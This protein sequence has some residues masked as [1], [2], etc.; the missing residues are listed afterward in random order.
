MDI[1]STHVTHGFK[2][3]LAALLAYGITTVLA[4][5]FGYWAVISTV[6]VMQV[7]VAD[8]VEMCLYRFTGTLI[9]AMLGVLVIL[10][11][12]KTPVFVGIALF[13]TIGIC[14]FLTRYKTRYRMA[15]I[16]VVIVVMTGLETQDVFIFGLSRVLEIGIGIL[17]AFSVS[18]LIFPKR[19]VD[20][21]RIKLVTQA[22]TCAH[23]C[24]V[25][26]EA[27]VSRQQQVGESAV[28]ELVN[29]VWNNHALLQKTRRHESLIYHK[30]FRENFALKVSVISR[31]VEHLRNMVRALNALDDH[32]YDIIM[33]PELKKLARKS[34]NA[35]VLLAKNDPLSG[36]KDLQRAI[37]EL[38][39][40]LLNLRKEGLVR[41]FDSKKL[42]QV[43]SFYS[44]LRYFA[45]DILG[46]INEPCWV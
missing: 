36:K 18:V 40:R 32:G 10:V 16:T 33:S 13:V 28:T 17:C 29:D 44:S 42:V 39:A 20:V 15:G 12:P 30:K 14:S 5:E 38:D 8:S 34:G 22:K 46:A 19:K 9:G 3:A 37:S 7:Y 26:V 11:I 25:L 27:F 2:T 24:G 21:L 4:L 45:E 41:R 23:Q 35:L 1:S 6:I 43:F 31:S